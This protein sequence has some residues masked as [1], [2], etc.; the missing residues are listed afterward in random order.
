[1]QEKNARKQKI[2][3]GELSFRPVERGQGG[4]AASGGD[5]LQASAQRFT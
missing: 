2:L 4:E 5:F 3:G 1:M